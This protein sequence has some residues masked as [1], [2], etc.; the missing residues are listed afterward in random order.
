M[1]HMRSGLFEEAWRISD[2]VLHSAAVT[3]NPCEPRHL[4]RVWDGTDV[5]GRH[6]LVRCYHGLGDTLQFIRFM[7]QLRAR[8]QRVTV[9]A[10]APLLPLLATV[11]G[12]DCLLPLHDGDPEVRRD[13]DVELMEVPHVLRTTVDTLPSAPYIRAPT[14][15]PIRSERPRVGLVWRAGT[16]APHRSIA[17]ADLAPIV[18]LPATWLVLQGADALRECPPRF[19]VACGTDSIVDL[20]AVLHS[21]VDL[22][23]T[24]DS[25]PAHLAG[26]LGTRVW[27]LLP[28]DADWRWM[29]GRDDSPWYPTMRL[30][31]QTAAGDWAPVIRSV[32]NT[33]REW[34]A[35]R[36]QTRGNYV[37]RSR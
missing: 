21:S 12:I 30:Y 29:S 23:I 31:R 18:S 11:D 37:R 4:Q 36:R 13:V 2:A 26:A 24:I 10:Q 20:A 5:D 6:V 27:T 9:W 33:L 25:M 7:R 8:A 19:G 28:A 3:Q 17:F 35:R 32:A 22:L 16:W 1:D 14:A 34:L 15:P